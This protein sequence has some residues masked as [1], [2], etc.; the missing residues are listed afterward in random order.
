MPTIKSK[1]RKSLI[2]ISFN[3]HRLKATKSRL[4]QLDHSTLYPWYVKATDVKEAL[5]TKN[6]L[7]QIFQSRRYS[8]EKTSIV[9]H[10]APEGLG[11]F[12]I[13]CEVIGI[14]F[15]KKALRVMGIPSRLYRN[16]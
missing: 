16:V 12:R 2:I 8:H 9:D 15:F 4:I 11:Y 3:Q 1:T 5:K 6:T 7:I 14:S 10:F 13:G